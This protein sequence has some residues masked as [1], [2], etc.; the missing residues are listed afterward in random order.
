ME[1][2]PPATEAVETPIE[3][4]QKPAAQAEEGKPIEEPKAEAP[5]AA[6]VEPEKPKRN[7]VQERID[8]ITRDKYRLQKEADAAREM[9]KEI[10]GKPVPELRNFSNPEDYQQARAEYIAE[11]KASQLIAQR[12]EKSIAAVDAEI[13]QVQNGTWE[14]KVAETAT[15]YPDFKSV[16]AGV[17]APCSPTVAAALKS[18]PIGGDLYYHLCKN[19]EIAYDINALE[20]IQQA[21]AIGRLEAQLEGISSPVKPIKPPPAPP[22]SARVKGDGVIPLKNPYD[23]AQAS[24]MTH[25]EF[26]AWEAANSS[27]AAGQ[28]VP[29]CTMAG[30]PGLS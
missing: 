18:S 30:R 17:N 8:E 22:P 26:K 20:P 21:R 13:E 2:P 4:E 6:K 12:V 19:P 11:V 5:P 1:A 28:K 24:T 9:V 23:P 29:G 15:K 25:E 10:T 16:V 3:G 27:M 14:A 7:R